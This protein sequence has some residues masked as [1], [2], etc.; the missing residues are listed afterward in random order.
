MT[1]PA[2]PRSGYPPSPLDV[3][4]PVLST[5]CASRVCEFA[6]PADDLPASPSA[7]R[8][9]AS[10]D[11]GCRHRDRRRALELAPPPLGAHRPLLCPPPAV[12]RRA[13]VRPPCPLA[14]RSSDLTRP[15]CALRPPP[16]S[17]G[18]AAAARA[19]RAG[20]RSSAC[21][22]RSSGSG[23]AGP[24]PTWAGPPSDAVCPPLSTAASRRALG[25]AVAEGERRGCR[26][27]SPTRRRRRRASA[28][29]RRALSISTPSPAPALA[30]RFALIQHPL[31]SPL[32]GQ[33]P[34]HQRPRRRRPRR[35]ML[36]VLG[37]PCRRARYAPTPRPRP[38]PL[39][40]RP[41]LRPFRNG[42]GS[43]KISRRRTHLP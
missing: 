23:S 43:R 41:R 7:A 22:T 30:R 2:F 26:W 35:A 14:P 21:P 20:G 38:R 34:G 17:P 6:P 8:P 11:E 36:V 12:P 24:R 29:R 32:S 3:P 13:P 5:S 4:P 33:A 18:R 15:I 25:R 42:H 10:F 16:P 19:P 31:L 40:R 1:R 27:S 37:H 9:A 28:S 39:S